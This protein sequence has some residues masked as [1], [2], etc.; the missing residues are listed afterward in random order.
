MAAGGRCA[1]A[2]GP[3]RR[4]GVAAAPTGSAGRPAGGCAEGHTP[5]EWLRLLGTQSAAWQPR[6]GLA[7][8]GGKQQTSAQ[9]RKTKKSGGGEEREDARRR[10]GGVV[11]RSRRQTP[12]VRV[13]GTLKKTKRG[14][15]AAA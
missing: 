7:A 10:P 4:T 15:A 8:G 14:A 2:P 12:G 9:K 1:K 11:A 3:P 5:A 6:G 13:R